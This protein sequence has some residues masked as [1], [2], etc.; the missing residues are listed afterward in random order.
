[1]HDRADV[2]HALL[3]RRVGGRAVRQTRVP[4]VEQDQ[5][6]EPGEAAEE[7]SGLR[8]LPQEIE[9][10]HR[11][12]HEHDVAVALPQHL[13]GDADI[14]A[15]GIARLRPRGLCG[16]VFRRGPVVEPR[17]LTK[18]PVV[19]LAQ[20]GAGLDAELIRQHRAQLPVGAQRIRLATAP[21]ERE[22]A[23]V[24][25]PLAQRMRGG[26]R[27]ELRDRLVVAAAR[28]LRLD[29]R[30]ERAQPPLLEPRPFDA[31]ELAI[32]EVGQRWPPPHSQ[33]LIE[34]LHRADGVAAG[35]RLTSRGHQLFKPQ[36]VELAGGGQEH[37]SG[38]SGHESIRF[39]DGAKRPAE[40]R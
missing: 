37:V 35:D 38:R 5:A 31:G 22:Q 40:L 11:A 29:P 26:Q 21:I 10:A 13:E 36:N 19:E 8:V 2:V 17:V 28:E 15:Q 14:A 7:V 34:Q 6:A 1:M 39:S 24:P 4:L 33:R 12:R 25:E 30:F 23:V 32:A 3:E 18:D 20:L 16:P 27:L 9:M